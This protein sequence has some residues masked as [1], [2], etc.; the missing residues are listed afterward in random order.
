MNQT[1]ASSVSMTHLVFILRIKALHAA[2]PEIRC[3]LGD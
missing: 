3:A 2:A 1:S